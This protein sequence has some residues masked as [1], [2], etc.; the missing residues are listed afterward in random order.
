MGKERPKLHEQWELARMRASQEG[1]F[2]L[3]KA[4]LRALETLFQ[5]SAFERV[6]Q[7]VADTRQD[8][9]A[10]GNWH[11]AQVLQCENGGQNEIAHRTVILIGRRRS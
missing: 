1:R 9:R 5:K 2:R 7:H 6:V 10:G 4:G 11:V 3:A 8:E